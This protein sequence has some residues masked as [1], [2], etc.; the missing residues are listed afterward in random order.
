MIK[1]QTTGLLNQ[2]FNEIPP[3]MISVVGSAV[4]ASD[5]W[6]RHVRSVRVAADGVEIGAGRFM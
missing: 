2:C 3:E 4:S 6:R 5:A 1:D